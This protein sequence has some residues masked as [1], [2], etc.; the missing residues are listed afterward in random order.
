MQS[1][2]MYGLATNLSLPRGFAHGLSA[3]IGKIYIHK[4]VVVISMSVISWSWIYISHP[5]DTIHISEI[6]SS[7]HPLY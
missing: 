3:A 2:P 1:V 6:S 7:N 5:R 4:T